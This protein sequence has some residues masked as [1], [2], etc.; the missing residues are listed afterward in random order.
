MTLI[1]ASDADVKLVVVSPKVLRND[2][3]R[4]EFEKVAIS[5]RRLNFAMHGEFIDGEKIIDPDFLETEFKSIVLDLLKR[6]QMRGKVVGTRARFEPPKPAS[7]DEIEEQL[8]SNLFPVKK[9]PSTIFASPTNFT[10]A[11]AIYRECGDRIK[12]YPFL[13]KRKK[14]Y[15]F[16]DLRKTS[17]PFSRIIS[18][19]EITMEKVSDWMQDDNKRNDLMYLLNLSLERYCRRRGMDYIKKYQRFVCRLQREQSTRFFT[20]KPKTRFVPR[21]IA[22][23]VT[24]RKG[25]ILFCKHYAAELRFMI[26]DDN[27]FLRIAP[28]MAFTSDGYHPISSPKLAS[29]MSRYLSHQY[30][31]QYLELV[32]FWGKFLSKLDT[33]ITIPAGDTTIEIDSNPLLMSVGVG[34]AEEKGA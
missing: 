9:Y 15:T 30:N 19:N 23:C 20:W 10:S 12:P 24:G 7:V 13:P 21:I 4:R 33:W 17:T 34:I 22:Q 2:K 16:N 32:R 31:N 27:I 8:S 26:I 6:V 3:Y 5:Q 18:E 28:T 25:N 11:I 1:Q 29:L 14:L